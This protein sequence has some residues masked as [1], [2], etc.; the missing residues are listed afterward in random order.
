MA[1]TKKVPKYCGPHGHSGKAY[2]WHEGRQV[3]FPGKFGSPESLRGYRLFLASLSGQLV[4][5]LPTDTT[6]AQL[7]E[8]WIVEHENKISEKNL[9]HYH[10]CITALLDCGLS[11]VLTVDFGPRKLKELRQ[12]LIGTGLARST[13]NQR[14]GRVKKLFKW[15]VS[16]E[17][18]P[19]SVSQ[20]LYAVDGLRAGESAAKEVKT[21]SPVGWARV[22]EISQHI[23]STVLGMCRLQWL[24]GMRSANIC[25]LQM[26]YVDDSGDVW[27]YRPPKHKGQWR[28][29]G[30]VVSLGP[31]S[32]EVIKECL[33]GRGSR[34]AV[35]RPIDSLAWHQEYNPGFNAW[36]NR[37]ASDEFTPN[38][39]RQAIMRGQAMAAGIKL[40][41]KLPT[42]A[43]FEVAGW[44]PW[45]PYQLRHAAVT[46]LRQKYSIESVR[47][48]MGHSTTQATEIYSEQDLETAGRIASE[49][50]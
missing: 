42:V 5:C 33:A 3:Y 10:Q 8:A 26:Q 36:V 47:A 45:T 20:A 27:L 39:Y 6:V 25:C 44:H 12:H 29:K 2:C 38:T 22:E 41:R 1:S 13:I 9:S 23:S 32:Q 17:M 37:A 35:F 7:A 48:Y 43:E 4:E 14:I 30:L 40:G 18:V 28:G 11:S 24:T 34:E 16:E 50:G 46:R 19:A 21:R 15:G 31:K 49:N